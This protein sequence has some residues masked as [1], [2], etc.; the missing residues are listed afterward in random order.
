MFDKEILQYKV[1]GLLYQK[2]GVKAPCFSYGDETPQ[3]KILL[4]KILGSI[5]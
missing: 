4:I 5:I 1:G 2:C 3:K